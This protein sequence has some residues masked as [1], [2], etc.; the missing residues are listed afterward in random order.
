M[1]YSW[2]GDF[3]DFSFKPNHTFV[4]R[5]SS[6]LPSSPSEANITEK[7]VILHDLLLTND[8]ISYKRVINSHGHTF[9]MVLSNNSHVRIRNMDSL[10]DGEDTYYWFIAHHSAYNKIRARDSFR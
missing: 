2:E 3:N 1:L 8:L 9:D 5:N 7:K 4:S 6:V 10:A